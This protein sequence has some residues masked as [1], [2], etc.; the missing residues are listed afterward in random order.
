M[1]T[2]VATSAYVEQLIL[3]LILSGQYLKHLRRLRTRMEDATRACLASFADI[4]IEVDA[5]KVPGFYLWVNLTSV[6]D[7]ALFCRA[8]AE[9]SIF[10]APAQVFNADRAK[11]MPTGMRVNV[12]YGADER[13][14][15]FL[16][17]Q[18]S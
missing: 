8:A 2:T 4:G 5:P 14:L 1:L 12:A 10:I 7:E 18:L 17:Q 9:K 3:E 16:R 15:S 11:A 13:F 6:L